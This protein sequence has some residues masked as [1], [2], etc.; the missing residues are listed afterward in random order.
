MYASQLNQRVKLKLQVFDRNSGLLE[1]TYTSRVCCTFYPTHE[2]RDS[3]RALTRIHRLF[4]IRNHL[5][6][7]F[8]SNIIYS[9]VI[10]VVLLLRLTTHL[11]A[12][13]ERIMVAPGHRM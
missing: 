7:L 5:C 3:P 9:M 13:D 2:D 10:N 8:K 1:R 11:V 6:S 4:R 12:R